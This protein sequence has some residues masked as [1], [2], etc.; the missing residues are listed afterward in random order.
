MKKALSLAIA[1]VLVA[2]ATLFVWLWRVRATLP[3]NEAGRYF[4]STDSVVYDDG[5]VVVYGL[6]ALLFTAA[7]VAATLWTVRIWRT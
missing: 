7:A 3:Y 4:D 6:L 1:L 5:A 2:A